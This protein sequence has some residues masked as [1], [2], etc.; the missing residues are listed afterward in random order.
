M[1]RRTVAYAA[2]MLIAGSASAQSPASVAI[3]PRVDHHQHL[4]SPAL[5]GRL[6][7]IPAPI[8]LPP[9][10][11]KRFREGL[12][13]FNDSVALADL[14]TE[15]A[16][17]S[18]SFAPTGAAPE[19]WVRGRQPVASFMATAF[20]NQYSLAP[21]SYSVDG[22]AGYIAGYLSGIPRHYATHLSLKKGSDGVWRIAAQSLTFGG[23]ALAAP[24]TADRLIALLDAAGIRRAAVLSLAY[25]HGSQSF[26][27]D[28]E[29]AQVRAE[30]DWT[31]EQVARFPDRFRA[32]CSFNPLREYALRELDR[33]AKDAG[34]RHGLKLQFANSGVDLRNREHV[35]LLRQ[36]FAAANARRMPIVAHIWT[37]DEFVGKPYG[38]AEAQVFLNDVLSAAPDIPVQIAHLAGAGPRL[39]RGTREA[40]TVLADAISSGDRRTRRLFFDVATNVTPQISIEDA[41]F[42]AARLRQIGL[43]RILY[44]SDLGLGGNLPPRQAWGAF[45]GMLPLTDAELRTIASNIAPYM[46]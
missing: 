41:A 31:R 36:V 27:G 44:G 39:D 8:D 15:D 40:L 6:F 33:C 24:M 7:E 17:L 18:F 34:L 38:R 43:Q 11:H 21:V 16:I 14:Y 13:R 1:N 5:A 26:R 37:G 28:D 42:I 19:T 22:A 29:Y 30:N 3:A 9:D 20:R 12:P 2:A 10:L 32:L 45:R 46:R 4:L 35:A 23:P 25:M